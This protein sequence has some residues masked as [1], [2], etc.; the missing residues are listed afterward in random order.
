[1][2]HFHRN[3]AAPMCSLRECDGRPCRRRARPGPRPAIGL[4]E[5]E[6]EAQSSVS[7]GHTGQ[8]PNDCPQFRLP[9]PFGCLIGR[10]PLDVALTTF[11]PLFP[12]SLHLQW[13]DLHLAGYHPTTL[14]AFSVCKRANGSPSYCANHAS[15]F[16]CFACGGTMRRL[17]LLWP[18]FRD[19]PAVNLSGRDE[20]NL[21]LSAASVGPVRHPCVRSPA[22]VAGGAAVFVLL[23]GLQ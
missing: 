2:D 12:L 3:R 20:H 14:D 13:E 17:A 10:Q 6:A 15:F 16:K 5:R 4:K 9:N 22:A 21:G 23:W 11:W 7:L 8:A 18:A 19:D 1:M